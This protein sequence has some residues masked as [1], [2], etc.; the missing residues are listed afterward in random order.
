MN[1]LDLLNGCRTIIKCIV[2]VITHT[3]IQSICMLQR[4]AIRVT[5]GS[6]CRK[7]C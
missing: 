2:L 1:Y 5:E 7:Y 6:K 3:R 4:K